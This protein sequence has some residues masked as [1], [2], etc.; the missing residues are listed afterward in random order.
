MLANNWRKL[1]DT[2]ETSDLGY[3]P[4]T[5]HTTSSLPPEESLLRASQ[6]EPSQQQTELLQAAQDGTETPAEELLRA[7]TLNGQQ[8]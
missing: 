8:A 6:S 2:N 1:G 7:T 3:A 4:I 5:K